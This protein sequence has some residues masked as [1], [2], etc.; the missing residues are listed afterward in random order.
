MRA[1]ALTPGDRSGGAADLRPT[2][3]G[4]MHGPVFRGDTVGALTDLGDAY[5]RLL[6]D[7]LAA[8]H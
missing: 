7:A 3:L 6:D 2:A 1:T 4:L 5:D 8:R